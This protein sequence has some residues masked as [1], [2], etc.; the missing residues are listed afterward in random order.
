MSK[1]ICRAALAGAVAL[2]ALTA[3]GGTSFAQQTTLRFHTFVPPVS[4]SYKNYAAWFKSIEA[5]ASGKLKIEMYGSN[6]LGGK[7]E[8]LYQQAKDG[9]V[10][11]IY[12]L[13]GYTPGVFPRT[14]VFELP[15]VASSAI[16]TSQAVQEF[17]TKHLVEEFK[18]VKPL[19]FHAP[20]PP[21][22]HIKGKPIRTLEDMQGRKIRAA[23]APISDMVAALGGNPV[24]IAGANITEAMLRGVVE[25]MIFPWSIAQANKVVDTADSHTNTNASTSILMTVMNK[26]K[27]DGLPADIRKVIDDSSGLPTAKMFGEQWTEDDAPAI[28]HAKKL[29]HEIYTLSAAERARWKAKAEPLVEAWAAEMTKKGHPGKQLVEDARAL[30]AKYER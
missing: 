7:P 14:E 29:G 9:V 5:K 27:Y 1:L 28:A 6:Q 17:S 3:Q 8:N 24:G 12:V 22:I 11:I 25:G 30:V 4:A 2:G 10:D 16:A 20:T 19:V 23:S 13:P 26:R 15:F 21:L 18:D